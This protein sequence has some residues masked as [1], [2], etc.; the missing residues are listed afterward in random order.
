MGPKMD[1]VPMQNSMMA[2]D[3]PRESCEPSFEKRSTRRLNLP[4]MSMSV[5]ITPPI[6]RLAM[7]RTG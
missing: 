6:A 2:V 5:P 7:N 1:S 3:R 4:W